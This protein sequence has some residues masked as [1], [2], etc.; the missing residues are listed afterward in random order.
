[1]KTNI[2]NTQ[3][4]K[5]NGCKDKKFVK[6]I[7]NIINIVVVVDFV[8]RIKIMLHNFLICQ[9]EFFIAH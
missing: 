2:I 5:V 1:M 6:F 4:W 7:I 9:S 3:T 8:L